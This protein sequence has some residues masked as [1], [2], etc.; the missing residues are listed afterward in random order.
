MQLLCGSYSRV[1]QSPF[2]DSDQKGGEPIPRF[3]TTSAVDA[4]STVPAAAA[5]RVGFPRPAFYVSRPEAEARLASALVDNM[6]SRT[7]V[8][9]GLGGSVRQRAADAPHS[10]CLPACSQGKTQLVLNFAERCQERYKL[11]V[12]IGVDTLQESCRSVAA[13][14]GVSQTDSA[15]PVAELGAFLSRY[16]GTKLVVLDNADTVNWVELAPLADT[17][18]VVVTTR[19]RALLETAGHGGQ[20]ELSTLSEPQAL[21]L[22]GVDVSSDGAVELVRALG[23]LPL[24]L[25]HARSSIMLHQNTPALLLA[26]LRAAEASGGDG[27]AKVYSRETLAVLDMSVRNA[28]DACVERGVRGDAARSLAVACG[29]LHAEAIPRWLLEEWL[30]TRFGMRGAAADTVLDQLVQFSILSVRGRCD[31]SPCDPATDAAIDRESPDRVQYDMHRV[32]QTAMRARDKRSAELRGLLH[33]LASSFNYDYNAAVHPQTVALAAHADSVAD[34][35]SRCEEHLGTHGRGWFVV[36]LDTLARW[37][38]FR[39]LYEKVR[40]CALAAPHC[41]NHLSLSMS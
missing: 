36:L 17:G 8:V 11:C 25:A 39:G 12:W 26:S 33:C 29:Y 3:S 30:A 19:N 5:V 28:V 27:L 21:E 7:V 34:H 37:H 40:A 2:N 13:E 14:L 35:V 6:R 16:R 10:K 32:L 18:H 41:V 1:A 9:C 23:Y 38:H 15:H 31:E 20:I 24:A 22:L 4:R